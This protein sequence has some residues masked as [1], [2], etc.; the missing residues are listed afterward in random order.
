MTWRKTYIV[1]SFYTPAEFLKK[2]PDLGFRDYESN[3]LA[4]SP[5]E[6][7]VAI[8]RSADNNQNEWRGVRMVS[9]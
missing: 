6:D 5:S 1:F 2:T 8:F 9:R 4:E 3:R 7:S